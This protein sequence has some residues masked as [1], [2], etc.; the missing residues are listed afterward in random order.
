MNSILSSPELKDLLPSFLFFTPI[1]V[2]ALRIFSLQMI[3]WKFSFLYDKNNVIYSG[4]QSISLTL[5]VGINEIQV[6]EYLLF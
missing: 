3:F 6:L 4:R 2:R 1:Y 5:V